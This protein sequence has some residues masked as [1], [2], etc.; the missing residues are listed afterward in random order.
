[1]LFHSIRSDFA[2]RTADAWTNEWLV[3]YLRESEL[4]EC[5][6]SEQRETIRYI[7]QTFSD[8]AL[9]KQSNKKDFYKDATLEQVKF[10]GHV[11]LHYSEDRNFFASES[12]YIGW[13]PYSAAEA[14]LICSFY[15]HPYPF[16]IRPAG[17]YYKLI[18]ACYMEG[19]MHGESSELPNVHGEGEDMI[20]TL[21]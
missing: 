11:F 17:E 13:I 20:I 1:M 4:R 6:Q 14:D 19:L 18:G 2:H 7:K 15:G 9:D 12:G 3:N 5:Y 8:M 16:I 21:V 10:S